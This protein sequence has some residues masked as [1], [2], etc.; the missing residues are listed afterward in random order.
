MSEAQGYLFTPSFNLAINIRRRDS[1]RERAASRSSHPSPAVGS[2]T[3][4]GCPHRSSN[5][6]RNLCVRRLVHQPI[7]ATSGILEDCGRRS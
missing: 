6:P 2:E 3:L 4:P 1:Y 5:S 7:N